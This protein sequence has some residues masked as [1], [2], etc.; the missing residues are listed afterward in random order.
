MNFPMDADFKQ[1]FRDIRGLAVNQIN[2][3]REATG[4]RTVAG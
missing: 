4:P 1:M 2:G 3:T